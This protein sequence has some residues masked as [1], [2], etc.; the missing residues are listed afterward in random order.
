[1]PCLASSLDSSDQYT[2]KVLADC[3]RISYGTT[4][5]VHVCL[6]SEYIL[7]NCSRLIKTSNETHEYVVAITMRKCVGEITSVTVIR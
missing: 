2:S 6:V 1:M 5:T 3:H 4:V 7:H